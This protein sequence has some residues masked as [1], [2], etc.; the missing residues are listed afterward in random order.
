[1]RVL[2]ID[3]G[4]KRVGLAVADTAAPVAVPRGA[5][6]NDGALVKKLAAFV[7]GER[8]GCV[9]VGLPLTMAGEEGKMTERV[10]EFGAALSDA[11]SCPLEYMDERLS[12]RDADPAATHGRD[13]QAA[14]VILQ[15][16]LDRKKP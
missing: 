8:V 9:V 7:E 3:W 14:A 1:M 15:S 5:E 6:V 2:G 13:A 4:E 11:I 10:R 12:S 16:W